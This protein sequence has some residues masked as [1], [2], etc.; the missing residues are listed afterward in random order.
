MVNIV[1]SKDFSYITNGK[2]D[3]NFASKNGK[4]NFFT[5]STETLK[6]DDFAFDNSAILIAGNGDFNVKLYW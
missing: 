6:C 2:Q 1:Q 4:Y 5:C 3:A